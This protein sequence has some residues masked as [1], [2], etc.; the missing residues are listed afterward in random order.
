MAKPRGLTRK[1]LSMQ[2]AMLHAWIMHDELKRQGWRNWKRDGE[3]YGLCDTA[4]RFTVGWFDLD[5]IT[6]EH[7]PLCDNWLT[8]S[9]YL[10]KGFYKVD[11][12]ETALREIDHDMF[13]LVDDDYDPK[14]V[15]REIRDCLRSLG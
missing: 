3:W 11:D 10:N 2:V 1:G 4:A 7:N 13:G 9:N 6:F 12:P 8:L 5:H 15:L 14:R